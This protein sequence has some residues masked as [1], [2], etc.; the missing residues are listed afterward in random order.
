MKKQ[1][2]FYAEFART[3]RKV[4]ALEIIAGIIILFSRI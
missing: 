3:M 1:G 4:F 2:G